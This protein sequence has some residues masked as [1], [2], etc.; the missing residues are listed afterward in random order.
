MGYEVVRLSYRQIVD[1]ARAVADALTPLLTD[2]S[3][4][5]GAP[6]AREDPT[7]GEGAPGPPLAGV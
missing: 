5:G 6:D 3:L 7:R 1:E 4:A 2:A